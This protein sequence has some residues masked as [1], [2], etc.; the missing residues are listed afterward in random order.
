MRYTETFSHMVIF[1][2]LVKYWNWQQTRHHELKHS[3]LSWSGMGAGT[4]GEEIIKQPHLSMK[5][6]IRFANTASLL[7]LKLYVMLY[8]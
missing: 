1:V 2:L 4:A 6:L 7:Q 3:L 8:T 5:Q